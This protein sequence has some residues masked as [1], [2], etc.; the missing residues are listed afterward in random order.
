MRRFL[1]TVVGALTLCGCVGGSKAT[2]SSP[3][4]TGSA[5]PNR[6]ASVAAT[7]G[8]VAPG[9]P[10]EAALGTPFSRGLDT[11]EAAAKNLWD[12]WR[13]DDRQ[14]ALLAAEPGAVTTLFKDQWGP[15]VDYQGCAVI[16]A[17]SQYRCAFVQ[18]TAARLIDVTSI[19]GRYRVTRTE[20]LGEFAVSSG[21]LAPNR[22]GPSGGPTIVPSERSAAARSTT[23]AAAV[24][25]ATPT[26][27]D[28][29]A[30]TP[31][32][33]ASS[34]STVAV[35][36]KKATTLSPGTATTPV[37][38]GTAMTPDQT[39]KPPVSP[40]PVRVPVQTTDTTAP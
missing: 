36:L 40:V 39:T 2:V 28:T 31:V 16:V 33:T 21:P 19:E 18:G 27:P 26:A 22:P 24:R 12:A 37:S 1:A 5:G 6:S 23:Q 29:T 15:E 3:D 35:R 30:T 20:R 9:G 10:S 4:A 11:P 8:L 14:R 32:D 17:S 38:A 34:P 7:S 13:D 25:D